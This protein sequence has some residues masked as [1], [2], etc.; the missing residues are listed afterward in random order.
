MA[1]GCD[2]IKEGQL[3][4]LFQG[5]LPEKLGGGVRPTSQNPCPIYDQNLLFVLPYLWS[6]QKFDTLFMTVAAGTVAQ[7]LIYEGLLLMVLPVMMKQ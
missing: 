4:R 3:R 7:N 2:D 1:K 5:V 6:D